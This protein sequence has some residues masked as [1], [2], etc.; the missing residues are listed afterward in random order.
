MSAL[1]NW[2]GGTTAAKRKEMPKNVIVDLREQLE[3]LQK[4][5]DY[6]STLI[7]KE[8]AN[9][10]ENLVSNRAGVFHPSPQSP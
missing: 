10:K 1:W 7:D 4:R 9:V 8:D 3:M 6:L 5:A 2:F